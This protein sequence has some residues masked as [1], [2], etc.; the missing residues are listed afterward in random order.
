[1][2]R[3]IIGIVGAGDPSPENYAA[4]LTL[5]RL[6]AER[7]WIVLTGGRPLGVMAAASAGAKQIPGSLT[8]GILPGASG[9]EGPDVDVAVFT[10]MGEARNAINVMTSDV[11]IACGVEGPGTVSE[12]ALALRAEKPVILLG[13]PAD[14]RSFFRRIGHWLE[15]AGPEEALRL[16]EEELRI[17]RGPAWPT[18]MNMPSSR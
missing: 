7:G 17:P 13:A 5:G 1:V 11:V 4:A 9:G 3:P 14:A 2:R 18:S 8:L 6:V 16:I 10:A 12:V 15:A